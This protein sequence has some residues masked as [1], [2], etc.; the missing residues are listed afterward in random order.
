MAP[1][2]KVAAYKV[3]WAGKPG[4]DD[5][6]FNSD[7][8]KAINDAV[9]D[10]VDVI[11]YS[12]GGT[13]EGPVTDE[14]EQAFLKAS[15]AG[16]FVSASAGNSGPGVS[17]LDHASPWLTTVAAATHRR[18]FQ[19]VQLGNGSRYVG[20]STTGP[21][22]TPKPLVTATSVKLASAPAA[23]AA[24]CFAGS[25]D[26]AKAAGKV[27]LCNRGVNDRIEKGFEVQ[28]VG[29]VGMVMA[30]TSPNSLNGDF[31]PVPAVHVDEN[32][33]SAI[34]TYITSAGANATAK[35]V[36]LTSAELADAPQ[37][38]EITDFSSRGPSTTTG[39]DILKPDVAAPGNDV[40]AAVAPPFAHGRNVGLHVRN[41][42]GLTAHRGHRRAD[43]G[44]APRLD[45]LGGQVGDHDERP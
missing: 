29:G 14:V 3:C 37:V 18:A 42:D 26:P 20:A 17:T 25:L 45:P 30:N 21:L 9:A 8:V 31:H 11:N 7:S 27:V 2:A 34:R 43:H 23:D 13:S 4:V 15:R 32:A 36:P 10:G 38:P 28:R 12:I 19:A 41:L 5:G 1:G 22:T 6:C 33:G 16:V 40:V 44:E 35:I 24:L 39:G